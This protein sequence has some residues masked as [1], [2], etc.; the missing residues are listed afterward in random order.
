MNR[1]KITAKEAKE[2]GLKRYYTGIP[3][4]A[5]HDDERY[6][7]S[8]RCVS[9]SKEKTNKYQ[10]REEIKKKARSK[11]LAKVYGV[12]LDQVLE[13]SHCAICFTELISYG[14]GESSVCVDHDHKTGKVRGFL[15]SNC[16]R[17]L[18]MFK[19]NTTSLKNAI[20][21]LNKYADKTI[22]QDWI[23]E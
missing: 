18:G 9:C 20:E 7:V 19:D 11:R 8:R 23:D 13:A 15:C 14:I 12:S 22:P 1:Q 6:V 4:Y 2:K 5:G 3:C 16:N 10:A 17:G 21:Y